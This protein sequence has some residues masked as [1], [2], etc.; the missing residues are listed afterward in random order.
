MIMEYLVALAPL[1]GPI[2]GIIFI[3]AAVH[4]I[5]RRVFK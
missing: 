3:V 2:G 5:E 4:L 1:A